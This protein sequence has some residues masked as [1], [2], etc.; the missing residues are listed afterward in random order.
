MRKC[1]FEEKEQHNEGFHAS[2]LL[3]FIL[4]FQFFDQIS[5]I[6][7]GIDFLSSFVLLLEF[8]QKIKQTLDVSLES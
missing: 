4:G 8:V 2:K 3:K 1:V 6:L 7:S 5:M